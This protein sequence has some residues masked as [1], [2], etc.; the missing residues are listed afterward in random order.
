MAEHLCVCCSAEL[1]PPLVPVAVHP[2]ILAPVCLACESN[3]DLA[4]NTGD[5]GCDDV[6]VCCGEG[7]GI[8]LLCD[9]C[10]VAWCERCVETYSGGGSTGLAAALAA[11]PWSCLICDPKKP[12]A[13]LEAT[14]QALQAKNFESIPS[15]GAVGNLSTAGTP[16][17]HTT[18]DEACTCRQCTIQTKLVEYLE[19]VE[20]AIAAAND[21]LE[22]DNAESVRLQIHTE[23]CGPHVL[24]LSAEEA[25]VAETED[26][27]CE[28]LTPAGPDMWQ[29][30]A[31]VEWQLW[32]K[33]CVFW[34]VPFFNPRV[35]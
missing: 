22:E 24:P 20:D 11:D 1:D 34:R 15:V 27:D 32:R 28:V 30:S 13:P 35:C 3:E 8:L 19:S 29:R 31:A 10:P 2:N 4:I 12:L 14:L 6:C 5:E 9:E 21:A 18:G 25:E 17:D 7:V 23:I 26:S 33:G 16:N